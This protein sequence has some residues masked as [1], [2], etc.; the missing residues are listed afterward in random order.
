MVYFLDFQDPN[1][2]PAWNVL[3]VQVWDY[4]TNTLLASDSY[5]GSQPNLS[6]VRRQLPGVSGNRAGHTI[7]VQI[8]GSR[9]YTTTHIGV[10]NIQFWGEEIP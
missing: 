4:T 2:D 5:D 7:G 8:S 6:C 3:Q 9:G 1:H 10:Y